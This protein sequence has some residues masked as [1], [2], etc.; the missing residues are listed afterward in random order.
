MPSSSHNNYV[1]EQR[2]SSDHV[3]VDKFPHLEVTGWVDGGI[4]PT[5]DSVTED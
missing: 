3:Y 1:P 2:H 5:V 4:T